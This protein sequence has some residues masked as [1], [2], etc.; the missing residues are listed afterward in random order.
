M[1]PQHSF[2]GIVKQQSNVQ[3]LHGEITKTANAEDAEV[4]AV[5]A[6]EEGELEQPRAKKSI[7]FCLGV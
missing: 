1:T 7:Q 2:T 4:K 5:P 3:L 6:P